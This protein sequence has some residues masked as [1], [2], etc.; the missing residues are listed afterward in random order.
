MSDYAVYLKI[1]HEYQPI[2]DARTVSKLPPGIY[3]VAFDAR[4]KSL[5]FGEAKTTHDDLIDL[6]GTA[7][8]EVME[9]LNFFFTEECSR[10]FK[11]VGL[12]QKMNILLYGVPG[13]GKTCLVNRV[14]HKMIQENGIVLFN[15]PPSALVEVFRVLDLLQPDTKVLVI[16]EELDQLVKTHGEGEFLNVLDGEVQKSNA[17]FIATT[18]YINNIPKRIKRPGR[19]PIRKEVKLPSLEAR[20]YYCNAKLR[21][22]ELASSIADLTEGFTIDQLKDVIRAHYCMK[23]PLDAVI[24]D[25]RTEFEL[26]EGYAPKGDDSSEDD[27]WE[28][29]DDFEE[30]NACK[31]MIGP[32][33]KEK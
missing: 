4:I 31:V 23:K 1:G 19:F 10:L 26:Q 9:D 14:T 29:I 15:P 28:Y 8:S 32:K 27:D 12:L 6:P 13:S 30:P 2:P 17:M 18:N 22:T 24:S 11:E 3:S 20:A 25:L 16:F 5:S 7:Y 33:K 21:N